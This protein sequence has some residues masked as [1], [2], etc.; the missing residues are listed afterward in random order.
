M[1]S[2]SSSDR[3]ISDSA[4][5]CSLSVLWA[6][7]MRKERDLLRCAGN[8]TLDF[9]FARRTCSECH[10]EVEGTILGREHGPAILR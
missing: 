1:V 5:R 2:R 6:Q 7:R 10:V 8:A 9:A 3:A 4:A